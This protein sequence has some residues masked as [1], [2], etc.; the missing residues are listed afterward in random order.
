MDQTANAA[1]IGFLMVKLS[2]S[3]FMFQRQTGWPQIARFSSSSKRRFNHGF[4]HCDWPS[5]VRTVIIA[6]VL[7]NYGPHHLEKSPQA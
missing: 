7:S 1:V 6:V 3:T 2:K 5:E 4:C